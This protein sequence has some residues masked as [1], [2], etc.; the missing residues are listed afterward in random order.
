MEMVFE[1]A[2]VSALSGLFYAAM[3]IAFNYPLTMN[4]MLIFAFLG[5]TLYMIFSLMT[6]TAKMFS[7]ALSI[8]KNILKSIFSVLNNFRTPKHV[9]NHKN[10]K[11]KVTEYTDKVE[12]LSN[13][14]E[15]QEVTSKKNQSNSDG[16]NQTEV[17]EVVLNKVKEDKD[18][19]GS[20]ENDDEDPE[21]HSF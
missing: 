9:K 12:Q 15:N 3:A 6:T 16:N 18:Q 10:L 11:K 13:K 20:G 14:L 2:L 21:E 1:T 17:K 7:K 19:K 8:P 4:R 5:S